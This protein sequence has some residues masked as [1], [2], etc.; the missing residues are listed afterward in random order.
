M[1]FKASALLRAARLTAAAAGG[2]IA[3]AG[4]SQ[5]N[6]ATPYAFSTLAGFAPGS[7][8]GTGAA[9]RFNGPSGV[10]F[11]SSGNAYVADSQNDTIRMITPAG[12]VTTIAGAAGEV[13]SDDGPGNAARFSSP[14]GVAADGA[15]NIYV[16][17]FGN[18]TIRQLTRETVGGVTT[19]TTTTIAGTAGQPGSADGKGAAARFKTPA[20][21][22]ADGSGNVYVADLGNSTIRKL[23]PSTVG[24]VTTWTTATIAGTAGQTGS[25]DSAKGAPLFD[26]D[27]KS[28]V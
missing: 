7:A 18:D 5:S 20:G 4:Y 13:G 6:Y 21:V 24:G 15:G 14:N 19:W 16:A 1:T 23:T 25:T 17:D 9:A 2:A 12:A 27:R 10:A 28:V 22:A 8:D 3:L 26:K 11:D